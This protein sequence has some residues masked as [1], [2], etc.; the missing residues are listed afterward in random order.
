MRRRKD[1][2]GDKAS[3]NVGLNNFDELRFTVVRDD[4]L[5]FEMFKKGDWTT[6]SSYARRGNGSRN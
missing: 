5:A 6:T 2:W 4:N 1:Y 3:A